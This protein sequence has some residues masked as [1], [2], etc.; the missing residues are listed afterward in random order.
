MQDLMEVQPEQSSPLKRTGPFLRTFSTIPLKKPQ[1][2][3]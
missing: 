2:C 3:H 1:S